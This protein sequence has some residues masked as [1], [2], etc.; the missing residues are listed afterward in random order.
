MNYYIWQNKNSY[1]NIRTKTDK[2][3][4]T[5]TLRIILFSFSEYKNYIIISLV[6]Y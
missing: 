4:V 2:G 6:K 1:D 5:T 3:R